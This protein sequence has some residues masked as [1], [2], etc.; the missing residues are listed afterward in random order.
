MPGAEYGSRGTAPPA[1]VGRRGARQPGKRQ[2]RP[3][4]RGLLRTRPLP[5]ACMR[6]CCH[7]TAFPAPWSGAELPA[8]SGLVHVCAGGAHGRDSA[9]RRTADRGCAPPDLGPVRRDSMVGMAMALHGQ[10]YSSRPVAR[11]C[12]STP[13]SRARLL[14][15]RSGWVGLMRR[16]TPGLRQT[17]PRTR[18][19]RPTL[20]VPGVPAPPSKHTVVL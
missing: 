1:L 13:A 18:P 17:L 12:L 2:K 6:A 15:Q 19:T 7:L 10:Y 16:R 9:A 5:P 11:L 4:A 3:L 14:S 20:C 8:S